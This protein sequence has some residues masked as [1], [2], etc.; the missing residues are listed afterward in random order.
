MYST[1]DNR[2]K[3]STVVQKNAYIDLGFM[4]EKK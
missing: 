4:N 2:H 1:Q 3:K